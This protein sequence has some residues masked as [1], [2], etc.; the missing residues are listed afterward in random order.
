MQM[1]QY[2]TKQASLVVFAIIFV[3]YEAV[4]GFVY[5]V[6]YGVKSV[7]DNVSHFISL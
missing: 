7:C 3:I 1:I 5:C 2:M 6:I 4:V